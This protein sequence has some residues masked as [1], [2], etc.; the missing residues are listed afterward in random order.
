M[1][2]G[3]GFLKGVKKLKLTWDFYFICKFKAILPRDIEYF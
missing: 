3:I 2:I 1:Q